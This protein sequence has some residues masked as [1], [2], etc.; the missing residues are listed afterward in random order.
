MVERCLDRG[1]F[2]DVVYTAVDKDPTLIEHAGERLGNWAAAQSYT[3]EW[4]S[5]DEFMLFSSDGRQLRVIFIVE[6]AEEFARSRRSQESWDLVIA[7][8]FLDLID[9]EVVSSLLGLLDPVGMFYFSINFDGLT[10]F[11][12]EIDPAFDQQVVHLYQSSMDDRQ[13]D[14]AQSGGSRTGRKLLQH[15]LA[16]GANIIQAGASDWVITPRQGKYTP[17]EVIFLK[18]IIQTVQNELEDH[19]E[20]DRLK[21]RDWVEVREAQVARRELVFIAHQLDVLGRP[22]R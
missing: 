5:K 4:G 17:D 1:L 13:V 2:H 7:H 15:L 10:A 22:K 11:I 8:A 19:P 20:L 3:L 18:A 6:E 21:F 14:G 12:P 9:L 16:E